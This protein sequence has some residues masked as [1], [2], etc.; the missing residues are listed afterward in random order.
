MY[1]IFVLVR[2]KYNAKWSIDF[3]DRK[4]KPKTEDVE[5]IHVLTLV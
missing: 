4:I 2:E 3:G 5:N 1:V